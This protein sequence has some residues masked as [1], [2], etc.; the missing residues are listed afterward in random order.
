MRRAMP[1][2]L[3]TAATVI[4]AAGCGTKTHTAAAPHHAHVQKTKKT[5][6]TSSTTSGG[7]SGSSSTTPPS[8]GGSKS[9]PPPAA[10]GPT[11]IY[12]MMPAGAAQGPAASVGVQGLPSGW[13]L[14]SLSLVGPNG[15]AVS[16]SVENAMTGSPSPGKGAFSMGADGQIITFFFP[17][18]AGSWAGQVVHFAFGFQAPSGVPQ[19]VSSANFT[20]PGK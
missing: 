18:P 3:I 1:V 9:T 17:Y 20:F 10:A 11:I 15:L 4:L 12:S 2:F 13:R 19:T 7:Q 16:S 8:S 14:V 5:G 6:P